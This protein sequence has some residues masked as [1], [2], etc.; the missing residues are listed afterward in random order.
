MNKFVQELF[1]NCKK[2]EGVELNF[3]EENVQ[4]FW[5]NLRVDCDAKNFDRVFAAVKVLADN[6]AYFA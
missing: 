5:E 6:G 4:I 2:I 3:C 1:E